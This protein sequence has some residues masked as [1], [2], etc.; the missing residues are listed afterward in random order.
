MDGMSTLIRRDGMMQWQ[1]FRLILLSMQIAAE[2]MM[3]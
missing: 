1:N 2:S 3:K